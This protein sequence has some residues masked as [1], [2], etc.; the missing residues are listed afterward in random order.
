[1]ELANSKAAYR[2]FRGKY[3]LRPL[4]P[5][6]NAFVKGVAREALSIRPGPRSIVGPNQ[7]RVKFDGGVFG[8]LPVDGGKKISTKI[9]VT[10]GEL[11]TDALGRLLVLG[12]AGISGT[13]RLGNKIGDTNKELVYPSS[14]HCKKAMLPTG[15]GV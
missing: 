14:G 10:L 6:R 11:R 9:A 13:T 1:V 7:R 5:W 3:N 15:R 12:G 4:P 2:E 8:P